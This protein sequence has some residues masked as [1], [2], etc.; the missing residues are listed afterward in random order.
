MSFTFVNNAEHKMIK[1]H[2]NSKGHIHRRMPG[3]YDPSIASELHRF[4]VYSRKEVEGI[5]KCHN[6]KSDY[7]KKVN[8]YAT[9]DRILMMTSKIKSSHSLV[10]QNE[11]KTD[12]FIVTA[13]VCDI[14][15][16]IKLSVYKTF[17]GFTSKVITNYNVSVSNLAEKQL[18]FTVGDVLKYYY[19]TNKDNR[20]YGFSG[21]KKSDI[22]ILWKL[23]QES[24]LHA[25]SPNSV[26]FALYYDSWSYAHPK[27]SIGILPIMNHDFKWT[28]NSFMDN[29]LFVPFDVIKEPEFAHNLINLYYYGYNLTME[30]HDIIRFEEPISL[31]D[32]IK[33]Y[34]NASD[35]NVRFVKNNIAKKLKPVQ[36]ELLEKYPPMVISKGFFCS[37]ENTNSIHFSYSFGKNKYIESKEMSYPLFGFRN[38]YV[39]DWIPNHSIKILKYIV[40]DKI[41]TQK[42]N[43]FKHASK[44]QGKLLYYWGDEGNRTK[45]VPDYG[46]SGN[47]RQMYSKHY[48]HIIRRRNRQDLEEAKKDTINGYYSE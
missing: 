24:V 43:S 22:K 1:G 3:G 19:Y 5:K 38:M 8:S 14:N 30:C 36:E 21:Y 16:D 9:K 20:D 13:Y 29:L 47:Y 27:F 7:E 31:I 42:I 17:M 23:C 25:N 33:T 40:E 4:V 37:N 12:S 35:N 48:K 39:Q 10:C 41:K 34:E 6:L 11:H 18:A 26:P 32:V 28:L 15:Y 44:K 2:K 45:Y 46:G